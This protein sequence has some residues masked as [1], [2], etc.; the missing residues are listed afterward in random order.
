MVGLYTVIDLWHI[1]C[2]GTVSMLHF[3]LHFLSRLVCLLLLP[4]LMYVVLFAVHIALLPNSGDGDRFMSIHFQVPRHTSHHIHIT[5]HHI[6]SHHIT[7]HNQHHITNIKSA[8]RITS[9]HITSHSQIVL[10]GP[11]SSI[12]L[13]GWV[14]RRRVDCAATCLRSTYPC[15]WNLFTAP[16]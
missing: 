16:T 1:L 10:L 5:S 4:M 13:F 2:D 3:A 7:S 15:R 14:M 11:F 6:A 8:H 9:H 12:S